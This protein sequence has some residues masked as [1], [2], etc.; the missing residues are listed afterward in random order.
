[1][2]P[3]PTLASE[4]ASLELPKPWLFP[5]CPEGPP[6]KIDWPPLIARFPWLAALADCPQ[7]PEWHGEG[8]V[9]THTRAVCGALV[10][11]DAWRALDATL[12]SVCFAAALLHDNAKPQCTREDDD[13][14]L[15]APGHG[16]RG[17]AFAR[18][19]LMG[20]EDPELA[21]APLPIREL[22]VGLARSIGAPVHAFES[23][24][25][26]RIVI[27]ASWRARCDLLA[28]LARSD[29][30][31]RKCPDQASLLDQVEL[32]TLRARELGASDDPY[33]FASDVVRFRYFGGDHVPASAVL[34]DTTR[35]RVTLMAGLPGAGKDTWVARHAGETPV[36]S[37]DAIRDEL[38]VSPGASQGPVIE[39]ARERAR[40]HLRTG[41]PFVWNATNV[42]RP[43]RKQVID[44]LA[45][46][47]A[48]ITIVYCDTD[49][50]T[51]RAR[52]RE[53]ACKV[54]ENVLTRL[55]WKLEVPDPT[56][57]HRV[58]WV[59]S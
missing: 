57:A 41:T 54:P 28:M 43:V 1:M 49:G 34:H 19:F 50:P 38:G 20:L 37:L 25:P 56:E 36:I 46:Y 39:A 7:D 59:S 29:V 52:N 33:R 9:L 5:G 15:V 27:Q 26:D 48:H 3:Q 45:R 42:S 40:E 32:F 14:R 22:V 35:S 47:D 6:W 18:R 53:R 21:P 23:T 12:R 58:A 16:P 31:G 8:D 55:T 2:T 17:A 10:R 51:L 13:G 4:V 44:L 11:Q 24:D 30:R